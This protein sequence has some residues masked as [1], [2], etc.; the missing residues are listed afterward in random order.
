MV[1]EP[2]ARKPSPAV[3]LVLWLAPRAAQRAR[4]GARRRSRPTS[5][6][7]AARARPTIA[8][9]SSRA[10]SCIRGQPRRP[11]D[12]LA[13]SRCGPGSATAPTSAATRKKP[14]PTAAQSGRERTAAGA[15]SSTRARR[16][17]LS[18]GQTDHRNKTAGDRSSRR[19]ERSEPSLKT[20]G[21]PLARRPGSRGRRGSYLPAGYV[22]GRLTRWPVSPNRA[23]EALYE[24]FGRCWRFLE[25]LKPRRR[26]AASARSTRESACEPPRRPAARRSRRRCSLFSYVDGAFISCSSSG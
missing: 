7:S 19:L 23:G 1:F 21:T 24:A 18:A 6:S 15:S 20:S 13:R 26:F 11:G 3:F 2:S 14:P 5:S 25:W 9:R 8:P 22:A 16:P 10:R 12:R 4:L 17:E